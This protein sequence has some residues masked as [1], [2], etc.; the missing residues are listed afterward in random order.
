M[1]HFAVVKQLFKNNLCFKISS[2]I[3]VPRGT[4]SLVCEFRTPDHR[5]HSHARQIIHVAWH[6]LEPRPIE[7]TIFRSKNRQL[8]RVSLL[9]HLHARKITAC[10]VFAVADNVKNNETRGT[11]F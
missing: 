3:Q 4:L 9:I 1:T 10:K 7:L 2:V 5:H 11:V 6:G 8:M